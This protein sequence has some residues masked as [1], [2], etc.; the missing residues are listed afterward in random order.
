MSQLA[1]ELVVVTG[2]SGAG[3]STAVAALEDLGYFCVD[4]LPLSVVQTTLH[5]LFAAGVRRVALG[6]DVRVGAF[7]E[8][9]GEVVDGLLADDRCRVSVLFLDASDEVLFRRFSGT[10]RPHPLSQVPYASHLQASTVLAG[11]AL[12][13]ERLAGL[14]RLATIMVDTSAL[15][16][17]ALRRRV[18]EL[19]GPPGEMPRVRLR[20]LSFGFKYGA[21]MDADLV[22]DVRFFDNPYFVESLR[23]RSGLDP[24]V[25]A[26][27]LETDDGVAFLGHVL[28]L[29]DFMLPRLEREGR[30]Y[31]TV[32]VGCT[33][34]M[35]RSVAVTEALA[36]AVRS[37]HELVLEV[38]HRDLGRD[39]HATEERHRTLVGNQGTEV[40]QGRP[41]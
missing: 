3:R 22:F 36:E 23:E 24:M 39:G 10:R 13:R 11:I 5:T 1:N 26:F 32:A 35:H 16:V 25:R 12:E 14:R 33:G 40:P 38:T 29:L 34:G 2:L 9:A 21:P 18:I 7:F 28:G 17:H 31:F 19:L 41:A 8:Q 37:H 4:N 27:V 20:F 30:S 6:I 15:N